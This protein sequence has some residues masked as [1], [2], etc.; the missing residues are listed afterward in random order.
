MWRIFFVVLEPRRE[1]TRR[2]RTKRRTVC[3]GGGGGA[4][5]YLGIQPTQGFPQGSHW[6][7]KGGIAQASTG[8]T[9]SLIPRMS[10]TKYMLWAATKHL[11]CKCFLHTAHA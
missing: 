6:S 3:V 7:P 1:S 8:T 9:V 5:S 11:M 4:S 10:T 2:T